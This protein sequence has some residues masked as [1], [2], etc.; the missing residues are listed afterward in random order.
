M[1]REE[2]KISTSRS[3]IYKI[4]AMSLAFLLLFLV[5]ISLRVL[6]VGED[7]AVFMED[8]TGQFKQLNPKVSEKYFLD[9]DNATQGF[10][11]IFRKQKTKVPSVFLSWAPLQQ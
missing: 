3:I 10:T 11:E 5:E 9:Q 4:L 1:K 6:H 2:G 7:Y 8:P